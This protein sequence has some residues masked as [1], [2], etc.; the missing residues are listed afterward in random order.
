MKIK[1]IESHQQTNVQMDGAAG[2]KMRMLV[3]HEDGAGNFH[4]RHFEIEPGGHSPHHN[5]DYEHEILILAGSGVAKTEQGDRPFSAGDAL[6]VP[7]NET[8]QFTN[9][10]DAPLQFIC[11]SPAPKDCSV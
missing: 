11:L 1:S 3:G 7:A 6:F 2:V 8:H 9:T 5:H 4:M 10:G